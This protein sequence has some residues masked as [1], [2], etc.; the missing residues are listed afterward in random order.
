[1]AQECIVFFILV[2][3]CTH[4]KDAGLLN[5]LEYLPLH[6]IDHPV[7]AAKFCT[8]LPQRGARLISLTVND[9]T[10]YFVCA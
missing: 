9:H 7:I 8:V 10:E 3:Q 5:R 1:M 4:Q 2:A 6:G